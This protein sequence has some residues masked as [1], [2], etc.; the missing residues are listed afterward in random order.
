MYLDNNQRVR[1]NNIYLTNYYLEH[2]HFV[3]NN[4]I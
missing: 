1:T 4:I 2:L 3:N